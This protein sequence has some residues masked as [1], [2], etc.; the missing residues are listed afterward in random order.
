MNKRIEQVTQYP[1]DQ[2]MRYFPTSSWSFNV[3][4]VGKFSKFTSPI[5]P[6]GQCHLPSLSKLPR[7]DGDNVASAL[8]R[9]SRWKLAQF[10][11]SFF[12]RKWCLFG[13]LVG[14]SLQFSMLNYMLKHFSFKKSTCPKCE[15]YLFTFPPSQRESEFSPTKWMTETR[16]FTSLLVRIFLTFLFAQPPESSNQTDLTWK[17]M[18]PWWFQLIGWFKAIHFFRL[19]PTKNGPTLDLSTEKGSCPTEQIVEMQEA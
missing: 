13:I 19:H 2:C 15:S 4:L 8:Q 16:V 17:S 18:F 12:E 11:R 6:M 7:W 14:K 3:K 5:H 9:H 1:L 10:S